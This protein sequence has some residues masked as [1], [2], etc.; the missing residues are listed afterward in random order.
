MDKRHAFPTSRRRAFSSCAL[1]VTLAASVAG[2]DLLKGGG[3]VP[4]EG[5]VRLPA[6][7]C[8]QVEVTLRDLQT[9]VMIDFGATGES[10]IE[11]SAWQAMGRRSRDEVVTALA[12]KAACEVE[13]PP[14]EQAVTVRNEAGDVLAE[15]TVQV[16]DAQRGE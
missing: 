13:R 14:A 1:L 7:T 10:T 8:A 4:E 2:C 6:E 16:W 11:Q 12:V 9:K 3:E 15:R 5:P